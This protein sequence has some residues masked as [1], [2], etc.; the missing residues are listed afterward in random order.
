MQRQGD[1]PPC[2]SAARRIEGDWPWC[3]C[4]SSSSRSAFSCSRLRLP[5]PYRPTHRPRECAFVC[6][7]DVYLNSPPVTWKESS[8]SSCL[9]G[10]SGSLYRATAHTARSSRARGEDIVTVRKDVRKAGSTRTVATDV[11]IPPLIQYRAPPPGTARFLLRPPWTAEA[12]LIA[13]RGVRRGGALSCRCWTVVAVGRLS[14]PH[15]PSAT[16]LNSTYATRHPASHGLPC[17]EV[18]LSDNRLGCC[19]GCTFPRPRHRQSEAAADNQGYL[20]HVID[21]YTQCSVDPP[22]IDL[23]G[24]CCNRSASPLCLG[25]AFRE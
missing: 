8:R 12:A 20:G 6:G 14:L 11:A 5:L 22:S 2:P 17:A 23:V 3:P 9:E 16:T 15:P 4:W 19:S 13:K 25:S 18:V 7:E 1:R 10:G 24:S 21:Q